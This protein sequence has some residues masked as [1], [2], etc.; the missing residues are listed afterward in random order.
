MSG[1]YFCE[2][3]G[4]VTDRKSNIDRHMSRKIPCDAIAHMTNQNN[5]SGRCN[6]SSGR[7]NMSLENPHASSP[8]ETEISD[9]TCKSCA[10][11]FK[12]IKICRSHMKNKICQ[13]QDPR[14]CR[15]CFKIFKTPN[16]R[17]CHMKRNICEQVSPPVTAHTI[18]NNNTTN[19]NNNTTNNDNRVYNIHNHITVNPFGGETMDYI[20]NDKELMTRCIKAGFSGIQNMLEQIFFNPKHPENH[21]VQMPNIRGNLLKISGEDQKW[22]TKPANEVKYDMM[23]SATVPLHKH[24]MGEFNNRGDKNFENIRKAMTTHESRKDRNPKS[25]AT[26]RKILRQ[27]DRQTTSTLINNRNKIVDF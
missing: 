15:R 23:Y 5:D 18:N 13:K 20:H 2:K 7:D 11:E 25:T 27:L 4:Y 12:T 24:Y 16:S 10:K 8:I 1:G 19:N 22:K 3:C 9:R 26:D 6:R 14:E 17:R 21:T